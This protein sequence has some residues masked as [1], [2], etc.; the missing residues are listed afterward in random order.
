MKSEHRIAIAILFGA[1]GLLASPAEAARY[2]NCYWDGSR[3]FCAGS[4]RSGFVRIQKEGCITGSRAYCCEEMGSISQSYRR[5]RY[6]R[7]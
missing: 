6:W 2:G 4:C 3:P 5:R 7:R 1:I